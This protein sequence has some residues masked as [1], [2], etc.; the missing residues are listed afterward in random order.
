[1]LKVILIAIAGGGDNVTALIV[2]GVIIASRGPE[3]NQGLLLDRKKKKKYRKQ[4]RN[5]ADN[6]GDGYTAAISDTPNLNKG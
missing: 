3:D 6:F 2:L 5:H 1:M 4:G